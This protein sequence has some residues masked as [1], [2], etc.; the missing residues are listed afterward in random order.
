MCSRRNWLGKINVVAAALLLIAG[1]LVTST[2]SGMAVPDWPLSY[3]QW[4]PAMTGGVFFEHGHR[5]IATLVGFLILVMAIWTQVEEMRAGVRRL[6]WWTLFFVS[7]Q[8]LL[9]GITVF[10][11]LPFQVSAAH[12]T[13]GQS[14][15][16]LLVIMAE[17]VGANFHEESAVPSGKLRALGVF[18]VAA[19]LGQLIVGAVMRHGGSGLW[20]HLLGA[21]IA[22][23]AAGVFAASV[24][25]RREIGLN[26]PALA[27]LAMLACQLALGLATADF[28]ALPHPRTNVAMIATATAHLAFGALLLGSTVL[29]TFRL[30][31]VP[32]T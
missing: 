1:G 12:A 26:K 5:M 22:A 15:F 24:L 18:A 6:A 17:C 25:L 31:R 19:L 23:P 3:G 4:L 9:G 11:N 8:G 20:P 29:L 13:L 16:C 10:Y 27:I 2:N 7:L 30:F 32:R 28:R 21:A 14:V